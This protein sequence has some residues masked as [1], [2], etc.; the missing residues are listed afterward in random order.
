MS[1]AH[2]VQFSSSPSRYT[3]YL[4]AYRLDTP[5]ANEMRVRVNKIVVNS[6]FST[7]GKSGDISLLRLASPVTFT[8][9][10]QPICIPSAFIVF[11]PGMNCWVTGWGDI[12]YGVNLGYPKNLQQVMV[13]LISRESCDQMYHINSAFSPS[14]TVIQYDQ[15][16]AGYQSGQKDACLGDSGGP[17]VCQA[18]GVWYQ[19][20]IVS[21]GD[22]CALPNR[23]GVYTLVS[24]YNSWIEYNK[25]LP[26]SS[27]SLS[28]S[29]LLLVVSLIL[30]S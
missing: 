13:P 22:D 21:W 6:Q 10:I 14:E 25:S 3:V 20:G 28:V 4:G 12:Q 15:I 17:L 19:V 11:P 18:N 16:C 29:V 7:I 27:T 2:C 30:H 5:S 8:Q 26:S 1:A 23:P 9:F 24:A